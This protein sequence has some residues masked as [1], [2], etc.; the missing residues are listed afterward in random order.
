VA[1]DARGMRLRHQRA[2][3]V[4]WLLLAVLLPAVLVSATAVRLAVPQDEALRLAVP[5]DEALRLVV[6]QDEAPRRLSP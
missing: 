2:H 6:P 5:Q 4:I 1:L 3:R